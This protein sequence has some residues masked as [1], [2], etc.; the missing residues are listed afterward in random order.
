MTDPSAGGP[1]FQQKILDQI[2]VLT[3]EINQLKDLINYSTTETE[4]TRKIPGSLQH[5]MELS[6]QLDT[7]S[8][9]LFELNNCE[10]MMMNDNV[11][12]IKKLEEELRELKQ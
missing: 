8:R 7:D 12:Y 9:Y 10:R 2:K 3:G 5:L 6:K 1:L 4:K 11:K